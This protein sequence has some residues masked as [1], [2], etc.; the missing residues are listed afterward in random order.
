MAG[1]VSEPWKAVMWPMP[2][3]M[4]ASTPAMPR[5]EKS[6]HRKPVSSPAKPVFAACFI[7]C[8]LARRADVADVQGS[9]SVAE[10]SVS[11]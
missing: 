3:R 1:M 9:H 10:N 6:W 7:S 5:I 4:A 11:R 2:L 8:F